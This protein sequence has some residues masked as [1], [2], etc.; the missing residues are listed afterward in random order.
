MAAVSGWWWLSY[1]LMPIKLLFSPLRLIAVYLWYTLQ[2]LLSP[3]TFPVRLAWSALSLL[4]QIAVEL[5][6]RPLRPCVLIRMST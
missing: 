1:V 4:A 2:L 5:Q 3:F 6:V